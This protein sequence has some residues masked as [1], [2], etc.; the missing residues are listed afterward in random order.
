[1]I[2]VVVLIFT[3]LFIT[4]A[5]CELQPEAIKK[6]A[7]DIDKIVVGEINSKKLKLPKDVSDATFIRRIYYDVVGR[8]PT[9]DEYMEFIGAEGSVETRNRDRGA[10]IKKLLNSE[11]Y[12]HHMYNFWA[13]L[14]RVKRE[15]R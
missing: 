10:L 9:H 13:D 15:C 2:K 3:A 6:H 7:L 14:L 12:V 1:M 11:G 5:N 8:P 4:V